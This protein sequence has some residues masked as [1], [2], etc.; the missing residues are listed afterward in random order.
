V[1][2]SQRD[3]DVLLL[4]LFSVFAFYSL[5]SPLFL[6]W[7]YRGWRLRRTT[8]AIMQLK[9]KRGLGEDTKAHRGIA[10]RKLFASPL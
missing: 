4:R 7:L 8:K 2:D 9:H 10:P 3:P 6:K 5:T 1:I